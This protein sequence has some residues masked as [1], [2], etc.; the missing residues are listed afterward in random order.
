M[1]QL[2]MQS[3]KK[4]RIEKHVLKRGKEAEYQRD[5]QIAEAENIKN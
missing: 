1:Q 4:A 3:V 2:Q 5:A